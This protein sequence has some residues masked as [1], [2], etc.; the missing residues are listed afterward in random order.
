[1]Q[2]LVKDNAV[3]NLQR[4]SL[5]SVKRIRA[6][7]NIVSHSKNDLLETYEQEQTFI[8]DVQNACK[9][10]SDDLDVAFDYLCDVCSDLE[11]ALQYTGI[12]RDI[13]R[14]EPKTLKV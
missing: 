7:L 11:K 10:N 12:D 14:E 13:R 2:N 6:I 1:M 8:S 3:A 4:V 9:F 5:D